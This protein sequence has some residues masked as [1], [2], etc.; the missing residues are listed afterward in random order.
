MGRIAKT[1][2]SALLSLV[3]TIKGYKTVPGKNHHFLLS[4]NNI[5]RYAVFDNM[6]E[7]KM[8]GGKYMNRM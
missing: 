2:L 3:K 5:S 7:V 1:I 6:R 8:T 4:N